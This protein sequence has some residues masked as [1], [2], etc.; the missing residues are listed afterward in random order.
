MDYL[1]EREIIDRNIDLSTIKKIRSVLRTMGEVLY[2]YNKNT[3]RNYCI[4][5]KKHHRYWIYPIIEFAPSFR[6]GTDHID[7]LRDD[8]RVE[9]DIYNKRILKAKESKR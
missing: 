3:D 6:L 8:V 5:H 1:A 4:N 7:K 9:I 2:I